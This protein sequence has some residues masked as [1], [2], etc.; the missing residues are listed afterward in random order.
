MTPAERL[1]TYRRRVR[2]QRLRAGVRAFGPWVLMIVPF[3]LVSNLNRHPTPVT[4][5]LSFVVTLAWAFLM[6]RAMKDSK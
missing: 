5:L 4:A 1:K 3:V 6:L 2:R